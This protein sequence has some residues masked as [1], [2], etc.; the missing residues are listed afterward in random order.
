[1]SKSIID[2]ACDPK[3]RIPFSGCHNLDNIPTLRFLSMLDE[4]T[5]VTVQFSPNLENSTD[6]MIVNLQNKIA[7]LLDLTLLN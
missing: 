1:M 3:F 5:P 2:K 4:D 7:I 6:Y